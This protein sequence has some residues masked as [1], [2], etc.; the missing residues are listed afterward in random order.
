[1]DKINR[2]ILKDR[3][4][5]A[6]RKNFW[7]AMLVCIV[8][9]FLG[10]NWTGLGR[11][12]GSVNIPSTSSYSRSSS[13]SSGNGTVE[14]FLDIIT[15]EI[16]RSDS[17]SNFYYDYDQAKSDIENM[18]QYLNDV[19]VYYNISQEEFISFVMLAIGIILLIIVLIWVIGTVISFLIGSFL[20]APVSSGYARYFLK[21][22]NDTATFSDLFYAFG[23]GR[24]LDTVKTLFSSNIRIFGWSLV[25]YFPGVV[26]Y[27]EYFFMR[28]IT[29]ENPNI[30]KNRAR[31]IS[32]LMTD[33]HKWE[34]FVLQLSF[35]GWICV[36][37][38]EE[39]F[40][41]LI[42]CGLLALPGIVLIYPLI[43]YE[44]ATY[45]ELY[46]DC[47]DYALRSGLASPNELIGFDEPIVSDVIANT[48][49]TVL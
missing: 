10:G 8:A 45:A 47:R 46:M 23:N 26:K 39:V 28:Y 21:N 25:F 35:L 49:Q 18:K 5:Q 30:D 34:I 27:Y 19:L 36:F 2:P 6:L 44:Q 48:N 3:A 33:G 20:G 11:S 7:M 4:K 17:G 24:Y 29:A 32:S 31:E 43:A 40:L 15:N 41:A 9:G 1:M 37:I 38:L 14:D 16:R 13:S 12:S 42:S 22:R